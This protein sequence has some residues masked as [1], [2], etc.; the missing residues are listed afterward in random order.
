MDKMPRPH[1]LLHGAVVIFAAMP[2]GEAGLAPPGDSE[3]PH[4]STRRT[5]QEAS[6]GSSDCDTYLAYSPGGRTM[7]GQLQ[8]ISQTC[9][10]VSASPPSRFGVVKGSAA[11]VYTSDAA[12]RP[13][14]ISPARWTPPTAHRCVPRSLFG[15]IGKCGGW[16]LSSDTSRGP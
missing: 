11:L 1:A 2:S 7:Q 16:L 5:L 8:L 6:S 3:M 12:D 13:L 15:V 14:Y 9:A 4:N 10:P